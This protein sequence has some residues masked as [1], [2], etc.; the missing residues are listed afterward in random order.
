V[1]KS[2]VA[3]ALLSFHMLRRAI[4]RRHTAAV[5]QMTLLRLYADGDG[6][7]R[8]RPMSYSAESPLAQTMPT[9]GEMPGIMEVPPPAAANSSTEH[10]ATGTWA[11]GKAMDAFHNPSRR[12]WVLVLAGAM[13]LWPSAGSS[14][15][16]QKGD[17]LLAED[18]TG[19]G[20]R[21]A[22]EPDFG[23]CFIMRVPLLQ[24]PEACPLRDA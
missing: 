9:L 22:A 5:P 8:V 2:P 21:S 1:R 19:R 16:L 6:E 7:S 3:D 17:V 15:V 12:Q 24:D 14:V 13:R 11:P 10:V 18:L 20:H 4:A 23:R